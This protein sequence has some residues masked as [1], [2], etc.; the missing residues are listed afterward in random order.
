MALVKQLMVRAGADFSAMR[1]EMKKAQS[2]I[3]S[4]KNGM[5]KAIAGIGA[6]LAGAGITAGLGSAIND[7][8]KF[9]ALMGTLS[10]TL[11][12]S[13]GDFIKWQN[14]VG[15]AMG[16]SKLEAA[17]MANN[18][19][20][21]LKSIAKDEQDLFNKTTSLI[22]AAAIIR[23][24]TGMSSMEISDRMR[25]A[26]NQEADGA[27]EL[28][29]NVRVSAIQQSKAY[30]ELANNA[31]WE[32][33]SEQM[34]KNI[35]YHHILDSVTTNFGDKIANNTALL[36]G[37]F[38]SALSD[39]KLA[40]GQA[41][42]PIVNFVLPA[43]TQLARSL[44]TVIGT[45]ASF[46]QSLF[47]KS[48]AKDAQATASAT[49]AQAGAVGDLGDAYTEAGKAAEKAKRGVYGFDEVNQIPD[50]SNAGAGAGGGGANLAPFDA[51]VFDDMGKA[52]DK[53]AKKA[54]DAASRI[55]KLFNELV[56]E[57]DKKK[58]KEAIEDLGVSFDNLK[59]TINEFGE[60]EAI[61]KFGKRLLELGKDSALSRFL[62]DMTFLKGQLDV[63]SGSLKTVDGILSG[64]F[65][66]AFEGA[67][68]IV[69][70]FY[71][72]INGLAYMLLPALGDGMKKAKEEFIKHWSA[73]KGDIKKYGD[74]AKLEISDFGA[75]TIDK[76]K[77]MWT[78]TG[79]A[80]AN[81]WEGIKTAINEKWESL[82]TFVKWDMIKTIL[83]TLWTELKGG[84]GTKWDEIKQEIKGK[85]DSLTT[86]VNWDGIKTLLSG[87][88]ND[89]KTA[90]AT[91]WNELKQTISDKWGEITQ[92]DFNGVKDGLLGIWNELSRRTKNIFDTMGANIKSSINSVIDGINSFID[93]VNAIEFNIPAVKVM[94]KEVS[95]GFS[96]GIPNI[97]K[98]P[99]LARGGVVDRKTNM[100]DY[101]A[102]EAGAEMIVPLE[103]TSF[104]DKIAAALGTAV[105]TAM[106]MN[107]GNGKGDTIIQLNG[108]ELARAMQQYTAGENNR[109][110]GS[111]ITTT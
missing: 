19:S 3:A 29:V 54:E 2:D 78:G 81:G 52:M 110:G 1:K 66:K 99:R 101:V 91:K 60:N 70:G 74:P 35:L 47:G 8:I 13:M 50:V 59:Q 46:T 33:L 98:I 17:E 9:E 62:G 42:L 65:E 82:K 30:K 20:L 5:S 79:V 58:A 48:S 69:S 93:K 44:A 103:N 109:L 92:I 7:A 37:N 10:V 107:Q 83:S 39:V 34:K 4:F 24:K 77:T 94:G 68:T 27:D 67:E 31:P 73:L 88:W 105:L 64:D 90:T 45:I 85:W 36:K 106:Q 108:V 51:G 95:K 87:K 14:T 43:L 56:T 22:K 97:P 57:E 75:W 104:T 15:D 72:T 53:A 32:Q 63:V 55:K 71:D 6:V 84:T 41:F 11:G 16:F 12:R 89:V 25:S 23:S 21:R 111:M 86:F 38:V 61:Q 49:T 80:T 96:L 102:G 40:I 26:M 100:G 18:Y 28:G 76:F